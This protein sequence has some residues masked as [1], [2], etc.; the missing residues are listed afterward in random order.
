[1]PFSKQSAGELAALAWARLQPADREWL[2]ALATLAPAGARL[3]LAGGAVRDA[4]LGQT[5]QD[6]DIAVEGAD[7]AALAGASGLSFTFHPAFQNATLTLPDGRGADLV[8][9]RRE[10]Y[11]VWGANPVPAP[12]TLE[13]DL[14]R[15][16]FGLNA[17]ALL[18]RAE[19]RPELL[20]VA[21]GLSDLS[22]RSLRPLHP[23]SLAEDASRLVRGARLAA[24]L[25]LHAAPELLAQ[26]PAALAQAGRTPRLWAEMR[27]LLAEPRPLLALQKLSEWGA[28]G[29]LPPAPLWEKLDQWAQG[30]QA[31]SPTLYAAAL[32]ATAPDPAGLSGRLG[33][34]Q[35]P[36]A[37]LQ[38]ARSERVY[39]AGTPEAQL[40]ELTEPGRYV[41]LSGRDLLDMGFAPGPEVGRALAHLAALR[42]S[43]Q[44]QSA[45]DE[46]EALRRFANAQSPNDGG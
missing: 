29:L 42:R 45:A 16:D 3:A 8:R 21:G 34:G 41:P 11:P 44:V 10:S 20:D 28:G 35:K 9:A 6:L 4:L 2:T 27:L 39:P 1:M 15:R 37:L 19:G 32:L 17:L 46:R 40:R 22:L 18:L 31:V 12:G 25:N 24:R 7:P 33:L 43:G 26:V 30:G 5:P 13:D 38:R 23:D 36:L 14:R